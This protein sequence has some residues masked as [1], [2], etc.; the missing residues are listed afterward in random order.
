ME[1]ANA[2]LSTF[3]FTKVNLGQQ[4]L[5]VNRAKV[6][7]KDVNKRQIVLGIQ[8]SFAGIIRLI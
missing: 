1:G 7:T 3:I 6:Y 8:I 2:Y 5:R 4:S